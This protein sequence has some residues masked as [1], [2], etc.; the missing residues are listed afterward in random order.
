VNARVRLL[1][2]PRLED[3][4]GSH[5]SPR[6]Q[7]S[8][9]LFARVALAE[10]PVSRRELVDELFTEAN[11]PLGALRW[12]LADL[13]RA[14]HDS[15]LFR[16]EFL[17]LSRSKISVDVW[18]LI[19]GTLSPDEIGGSFLEGLSVRDCPGFDT[20]VM[21]TRGHLR[22]RSLEELRR[23]AL[24]LLGTGQTERS[25]AVAGRAATLE[26]LD[27]DAQELFLRSLVADG[28][29]GLAALHLAACEATFA[30]E[31]LIISAALR[32]AVRL[33]GDRPRGRLQSGVVASSLLRAGSDALDAGSVDAG[34]ETLRRAAEEA[35]ISSDEGLHIDVLMTLGAALVHA[36]RGF[37]GEGAIILHRGM[38]LAR[39]LGDTAR[40]AECLR[41][42]AFIDVQAGR[43]TSAD[44]SLSEARILAEA[45]GDGALMAGVLA[46]AG[47]NLADQ[48]RHQEAIAHLNRSVEIA[49]EASR[50]RQEAWSIGVLARS[51]QLSGGVGLSLAAADASIR[52]C[53]RE[54]WNAF[55]PWPQSWRANALLELGRLDEAT[56]TA[57][58]AFALA[59]ELG[60][61]CWEGMAA[62]SLALLSLQARD[63]P[64]AYQWIHDAKTRC[65]RIQ[66]RYVWVSAY[67][68]L[69]HLQIVS[70]HKSSAI[71]P[72]ASKLHS[73]AIRFDLPE[74]AKW[75]EAYQA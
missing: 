45:S 66:D 14:L 65:N 55:L 8:W 74:I 39:S 12:C 9:A 6:G 48:G 4:T 34:I 28:R 61:P 43:H 68:D 69:A 22:A 42:L 63:L 31:G 41:E 11:D 50:P 25:S 44:R 36:T 23:E 21:L 53:E 3:P 67:V 59:C 7:K 47:M 62:R 18:E 29:P 49:H 60:D 27:E 37:D 24:A 57:Q 46:I 40:V 5:P 73:D 15:E 52:M 2:P 16:G 56:E 71:E 70:H 10:R 54:R 19:E 33:G 13:R 35:T 32:A 26:P 38:A 64:S 51:L 58:K 1:G 75:A 30:R 20:W 17:S 72:L